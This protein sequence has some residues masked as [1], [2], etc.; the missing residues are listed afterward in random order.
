MTTSAVRAATRYRAVTVQT[1]GPGTVLLMLLD[2]MFRFLEEARAASEADDRARAGDRIMRAHAILSELAA[3]LDRSAA[4]EL[5]ENLESIYLFCM[6]RLVEANLHRDPQRIG[7]V[8]RIMT[9]VREAF[10]AAISQEGR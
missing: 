4:P 7:D 6:S 10:R 8:V 2:G 3:T 5:C 9:P 1:A